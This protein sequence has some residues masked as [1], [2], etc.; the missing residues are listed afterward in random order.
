ML[1]NPLPKGKDS[2]TLLLI[3]ASILI[4]LAFISAIGL[5]YLNWKKGEKSFLFRSVT[6]EKKPLLS[7]EN[8]ETI[9]LKSLSANRITSESV[10]QYRDQEG[11][12][13]FMIN[14]PIKKFSLLRNIL[15]NEFKKA[16]ASILKKEEQKGEEQDYYLW[17]VQGRR[18]QALMILFACQKPQIAK[19]EEPYRKPA[20]NKVV[21]IVD[22]MGYSLKAIR[23]ICSI[24][25]PLTVSILPFTPLA[26]ETARI[27][28]QNNLEVMLHLPMESINS[29][30]ANNDIEGIIHSNMTEEEI[31]E[32]VLAS[33]EQVP[34]IIGVNNHMG[35]KIT[36]DE[37]LMRI[38]LSHLKEKN[39]YYVDSRTTGKSLAFSLAKR[40]GIPTIPRHVFLDTYNDEN[41]IK[42]KLL[43]LFRHA[44]KNGRAVGIC[45]PTET[46]LKVLKENFHLAEEYDLEP[47]FVS[48]IVE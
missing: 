37:I 29:Q 45:H 43:E 10:H 9:V 42:K 35:S 5:D 21:I 4:I 7:Q 25:L 24:N 44:Q 27:A 18:K 16:R 1:K 40:M 23:D 47:A 14:L 22:D 15:E 34:F 39:L 30:D 28:Q 36:A 3:Q 48:Q 41:Y 17:H 38:I 6:E 8:P 19:E 20:K 11:I 2:Q 26:K 13:H 46:T 33:L 12:L 32:T 31:K